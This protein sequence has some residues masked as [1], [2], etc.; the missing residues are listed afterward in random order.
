MSVKKANSSTKQSAAETHH[1]ANVRFAWH[2]IRGAVP[3]DWEVTAYAVEDRVGRLEFNTRH[4]L[5]AVVSWEPCKREPDRRTTMISFLANNIIGKDKSKRSSA[6]Q[7][8]SVDLQ[9]ED[10]GEFLL[11][12]LDE[13]K[14]VQAMAYKPES[15]HLIRW[16]FE[17]HSTPQGREKIIRPILKSCD[18]NNDPDSCEYNLHGIHC[19]LP[20]DYK[21]ED[22]VTLPANVMMSFESEA[23]KRRAVFRR[24]GMA[25]MI[26]TSGDLL[27]FYKPVL[28]TRSI[29][30][31]ECAPCHVN[32]H[33]GLVCKFD[34][35][36]EFHSDRFMRRR[37]H[38]GIAVIWHDRPANRIYT[39]EQIGPDKTPELDFTKTTMLNFQQ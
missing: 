25:D 31:A 38:N 23:T 28:R 12:W 32:G 3:A 2:H 1:H 4:G 19:H 13:S 26:F 24:W 37:W 5:Q 36:R 33:E 34:A 30:V 29:N 9:T 35:P 16:I 6:H 7:L 20:R 14:P 10:C 18:L 17:G 22:I 27:E 15:K 8:R 39:F 21:I 11:G